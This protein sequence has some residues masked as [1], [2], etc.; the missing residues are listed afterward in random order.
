M[1]DFDA[2]ADLG[3]KIIALILGIGGTTALVVGAIVA[4]EH[5]AVDRDALVEGIWTI[6]G[7]LWG[8]PVVAAIIRPFLPD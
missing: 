5:P 7:L 1:I 6:A 8:L 4:A 2:L 3:K